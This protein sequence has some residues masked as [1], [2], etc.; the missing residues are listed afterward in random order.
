MSDID[1]ES[2]LH[3]LVSTAGVLSMCFTRLPDVVSVFDDKKGISK[4]QRVPVH[5]S[6]VL[7]C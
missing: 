1:F 4:F 7:D 2:A 3:L 6:G 5:S